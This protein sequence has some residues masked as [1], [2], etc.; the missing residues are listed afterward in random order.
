VVL[1]FVERLNGKNQRMLGDRGDLNVAVNLQ[2]R[3]QLIYDLPRLCGSL[4]N[5][6]RKI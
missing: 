6:T 1:A 2:G 3:S 4:P 5:V